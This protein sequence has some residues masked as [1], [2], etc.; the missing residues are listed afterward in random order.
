MKKANWI[1]FVLLLAIVIMIGA[2][3]YL[4][5]TPPQTEITELMI[6]AD[7]QSNFVYHAP[8]ELPLTYR[9]P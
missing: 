8:W 7:S 4:F 3:I 5:S 1:Q 6:P 9:F 2:G